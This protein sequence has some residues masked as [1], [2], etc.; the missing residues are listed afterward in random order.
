MPHPAE[1]P[2]VS[3]PEHSQKIPDLSWLRHLPDDALDS[4]QADFKDAIGARHWTELNRL[5]ISWRSTALIY[6]DPKL[7]ARLANP[8]G[9]DCDCHCHRVE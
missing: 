7:A 9:D 8:V 1:N 3:K 5:L 4:F 2:V 6:S